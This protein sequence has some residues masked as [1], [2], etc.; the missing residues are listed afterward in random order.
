LLGLPG[1]ILFRVSC[2][3]SSK[4]FEASIVIMAKATLAPLLV[5][6][7]SARFL[8]HTSNSTRVGV[9]SKHQ[10]QSAKEQCNEACG[11]DVD[12][13]CYTMC[14]VDMYECFDTNTPPGGEA[15]ETCE[16]E[17]VEKYKGFDEMWSSAMFFVN[18]GTSKEDG[19]CAEVC[20]ID[21]QCKTACEVEMH[22]C[23]DTNTP[24]TED[25]IPKCQEEV[26]AKYAKTVAFF[27]SHG[28][29]KERGENK[30]R[31]C[32]VDAMCRTAC[33]TAMYECYD[34][35]TPKSEDKIKEC[36]DEVEKKYQS[37]IKFFASLKNR[38]QGRKH[39]QTVS[40]KVWKKVQG[41]CDEACGP[42]PDSK[43]VTPC[44]VAVVACHDNNTPKSEDKIDQCVKDVLANVTK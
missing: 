31:N 34:V 4:F 41:D 8:A 5:T 20:G 35:N 7:A 2:S 37:Q 10:F 29:I 38:V 19:K 33:E 22:T 15:I 9:V 32:G 23:E 28:D 18:K 39:K 14:E 21:S 12:V 44:E 43:C 16:A 1:E 36:Q 25:A 30:C 6:A 26:E 3:V 27:A 11:E 17:V 42:D 13:S 24:K 40:M